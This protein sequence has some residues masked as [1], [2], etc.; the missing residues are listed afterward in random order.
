MKR[1]LTEED[2]RTLKTRLDSLKE[3][4][5]GFALEIK[6][7]DFNVNELL[8]YKLEKKKKELRLL[9]NDIMSRYSSNAFSIAELERA[10]Y[11]KKY[12]IKEEDEQN[13]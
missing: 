6:E 1:Q 12:N 8:D 3:E 7:L 2:I 13:D 5:R 4:Q 10:I 9:R 11:D